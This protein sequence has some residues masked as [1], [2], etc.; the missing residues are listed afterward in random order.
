MKFNPKRGTVEEYQ[1][2]DE[3]IAIILPQVPTSDDMNLPNGKRRRGRPRKQQREHYSPD[4]EE[5]NSPPEYGSQSMLDSGSKRKPGR[6]RKIPL[7]QGT[8]SFMDGAALSDYLRPRTSDANLPKS[9]QNGLP[10]PG[11]SVPTFNPLQHLAYGETTIVSMLV[12]YMKRHHESDVQFQREE[13]ESRQREKSE[14]RRL[15]RERLEVK[16]NELALQQEKWEVEKRE[17]EIQM[18]ILKRHLSR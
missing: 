2:R 1:K 5:P 11:H 6:P 8:S 14:E 7:G 10:A 13:L 16:R 18:E 4:E 12:E 9:M 3:L 17:R 15:E